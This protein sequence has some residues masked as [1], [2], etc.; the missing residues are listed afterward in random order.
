MKFSQVIKNFYYISVI[1]QDIN[2]IDNSIDNKNTIDNFCNNL[3]IISKQ[4][5]I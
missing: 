4:N 5:Q 3:K 1:F 2:S